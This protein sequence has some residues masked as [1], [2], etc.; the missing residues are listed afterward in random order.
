VISTDFT[1]D[2]FWYHLGNGGD[3]DLGYGMTSQT[4][5]KWKF[6][7]KIKALRCGIFISGHLLVSISNESS[8]NG[9]E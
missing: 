6:Q 2:Y 1:K 9:L 4:L 7:L 5:P 8:K 3:E